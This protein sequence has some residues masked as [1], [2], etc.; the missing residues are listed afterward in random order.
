M[1]MPMPP[2]LG[3]AHFAFAYAHTDSIGVRVSYKEWKMEY[4]IAA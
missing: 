1:R 3:Y 2:E 4:V